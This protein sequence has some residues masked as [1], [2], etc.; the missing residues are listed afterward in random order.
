MK[1][2]LFDEEA[3]TRSNS[4]TEHGVNHR[5]AIGE[6]I[7]LPAGASVV[8]PIQMPL[9]FDA[10]AIEQAAEAT[11]HGERFVDRLA[12]RL[13][14]GALHPPTHLPWFRLSA[15]VKAEGALLPS[16]ASGKIRCRN[17]GPDY[18]IRPTFG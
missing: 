10:E 14:L 18:S 11:R 12:G 17:A 6:P 1:F 5:W 7:T 15:A 4:G 9:P 2:H 8:L 16:R 3:G 13:T